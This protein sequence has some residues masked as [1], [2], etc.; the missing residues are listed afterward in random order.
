M[1]VT[2]YTK[3]KCPYCNQEYVRIVGSGT[4]YEYNGKVYHHEICGYC[5]EEF[6]VRDEQY[7][8]MPENKNEVKYHSSWMS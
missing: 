8:K 3:F 7:I 1:W 5:N 4:N 6:L 2:E